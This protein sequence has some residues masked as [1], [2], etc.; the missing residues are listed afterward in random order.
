MGRGPERLGDLSIHLYLRQQPE[1]VP[2]ELRIGLSRSKSAILKL[3][4]VVVVPKKVLSNS[5][6]HAV[7]GSVKEPGIRTINCGSTLPL[8]SQ[9]P[10]ALD[11]GSISGESRVR[12]GAGRTWR[13]FGV[14][15]TNLGCLTT[16][17]R[18]SVP[19][20]ARLH[21]DRGRGKNE[22]RL[23]DKGDIGRRDC[24]DECNRSTCCPTA[25]C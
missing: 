9:A 5:S 11:D 6:D 7:A 10:R 22:D 20:L 17:G 14:H 12:S 4:I 3:V 2:K 23:S 13:S 24:R 25:P 21:A 15:K 1:P 8:P 19:A 16:A 18:R